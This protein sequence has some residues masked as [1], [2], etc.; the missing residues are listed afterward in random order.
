[1][2][3]G[4]PNMNGKDVSVTAF[5]DGNPVKEFNAKSFQLKRNS[6]EINDP[7]LGASRDD[8]D[9]IT[10]SFSLSFSIYTA[11]ADLIDTLLAQQAN[12]DS[13][14]ATVDQAVSFRFKTRNGG[15]FGLIVSGQMTIDGW[16][17]GASGR[18]ERVMISVPM[19]AQFVEKVTL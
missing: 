3:N 17:I 11:T 19:R 5:R 4:L 9:S 14:A 6:T 16:E 10:N 1:M 12:E 7:V 8:L 18:S 15:K 2:S 13:N